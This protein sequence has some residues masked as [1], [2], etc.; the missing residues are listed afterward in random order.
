[1]FVCVNVCVRLKTPTTQPQSLLPS[2]PTLT[3][4]ISPLEKQK[5]RTQVSHT[6]LYTLVR[7][8]NTPMHLSKEPREGWLSNVVT[9]QDP[10]GSFQKSWCP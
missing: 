4:P 8:H 9:H 6:S 1:M 10:G 5:E 2:S 3:N 7:I